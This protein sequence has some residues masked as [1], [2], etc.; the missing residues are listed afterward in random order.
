MSRII[1]AEVKKIERPTTVMTTSYGAAPQK[2]EHVFLV[3]EDEDGVQGWGESTPLPEF[4]GETTSVV[5]MI[6]EQVL[7]PQVMGVDSFD[8]AE[9]HKIMDRAIYGNH[10]AKM[11]VDTALYDL[12]AKKLGIPLYDLLGGKARE[13]SPINRHIGIVPTE[14]AAAIARD[15]AAAGFSSIKIKV[16][17]DV[18]ADAAR[19]KAVRQAAGADVSLRVDANGGYS[20]HDAM[21][22]IDAT[23]SCRIDIFEQLLPKERLKEAAL[24]RRQTGIQ[25]CADEGI[26]SPQ[27]G[28][29]HAEM[30]AADLFTIKLV[31]TGGFYPALQIAA[32]AQAAGIGCIVV[33]TFDTQVNCAA[34][35]HLACSL[36][37]AQTANDLTCFATQPDMA[38]SC[39]ELTGDFLRVGRGRGIGVMRLQEFEID[40]NAMACR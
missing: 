17:A 31:K 15:Y 6:L 30:G 33:N 7:L 21:K 3:L 35:L 5:Q 27:D 36:P 16:G 11:A 26:C 13:G 9:T 10:A 12:N 24:I 37:G 39:H 8:I 22:F 23:A 25:L 18:S 1:K 38:V 32:I 28:L 4:S 40:S 34:C 29:R 19:V 20:F 14:K 2:K